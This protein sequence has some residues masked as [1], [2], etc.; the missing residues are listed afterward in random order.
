VSKHIKNISRLLDQSG[1]NEVREIRELPSSGSRRIYFRIRFENREPLIAAYNEDTA[2]NKA[3]HSFTTHFHALGFRVPEIYAMSEDET[4]FLIR[5]LGSTDLFSMVVNGMDDQTENLYKAALKDLVRF[6][7]SGI[8]GLDLSI[9]FPVASFDRRSII[10][11]LNYFKYYFIR[12]HELNYSESGLE[13]DFEAFASRL[14]KADLRY[15]MYRDFQ[16]RNILIFKDEPWYID[17]QGGRRGPLMY[18]VV[19]LLY[20]AKANLSESARKRFLNHYLSE[21]EKLL[22]GKSEEFMALYPYFIFFR[23]MQVLGAYGFRGLV[24]RKGH[25]LTSIPYALENLKVVLKDYRI[26]EEF[27][28]LNGIFSQ[29]LSLAPYRSVYLPKNKLTVTIN[30]FSFKKHGYPVDFTANG[31]GHVFDCRALPNPGRLPELR[32]FSGK[33][34]QIIAYLESKPEVKTF[35]RDA[36]SLVDKSVDNYLDRG[37]EHLEVSFGCTGGKHRSVYNAELLVKHLRKYK[38]KLNVIVNHIQLDD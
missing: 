10:W 37:F 16:S 38:S 21:L 20:Q 6:Q 18:D 11:D 19:S 36:F 35:A 27:E 5:D 7:V 17:F 13:D 29:I 30:S 25:F 3:W 28:E 26:D 2:E 15:F 32:D 22:P 8:K 24:Q 14:L 4:Y 12:P 34:P 1:Y 31:G 33:D 9:A 23:L